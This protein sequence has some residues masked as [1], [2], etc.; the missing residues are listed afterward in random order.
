MNN[1]L[2]RQLARGHRVPQSLARLPER[3]HRVV[4]VQTGATH[5]ALEAR[6]NPVA[7][8][9]LLIVD[10]RLHPVVN[11]RSTEEVTASAHD[12]MHALAD[13]RQ[14]KTALD[15][16]QAFEQTAMRDDESAGASIVVSVERGRTDRADDVALGAAADVPLNTDAL[17]DVEADVVCVVV[18]TDNLEAAVTVT[19]TVVEA[20][21]V[22]AP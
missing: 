21:A 14:A 13:G 18:E 11:T 4:A 10:K 6:T 19:V 20:V 17:V 3:A 16:A 5:R 12:H 7:V 9:P 8:G 1:A 22:V 2:N 15:C